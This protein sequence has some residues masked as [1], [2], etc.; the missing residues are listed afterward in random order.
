MV[1]KEYIENGFPVATVLNLIGLS[2]SSYYYTP[3]GTKRG[4]RASGF[5]FKK[6]G[7]ALPL[8]KV[9]EDIETLLNG[10]FVDYGYYKT[11]GDCSFKC[12]Y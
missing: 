11:Y 6:E 2:R 8:S 12:V 3:K 5:V 10:E 9:V 7:R 1:A 4:K